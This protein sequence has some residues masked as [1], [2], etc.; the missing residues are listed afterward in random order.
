MTPK[1][2]VSVLES[3]SAAKDV[4]L[5]GALSLAGWHESHLHVVHVGPSRGSSVRAIADYTSRVGADL[6]VVGK[7]ASFAAA[8]GTAANIPTIAFPNDAAESAEAST[9]FRHILTAIDFSKASFLALSEALALAQQS[10][11]RL[12]LLHVLDGF[13]YESVYSGSRAL[14][15]MRDFRARVATVNRELQSLIPRAALNWGEIEVAT[16]YGKAHKAILTAASERRSDLIVLGLPR[17]PRLEQFLAGSTAHSVLRRATSPVLLVPGP[18]TVSVSRLADEHADQ[19]A[20]FPSAVG[21]R[22]VG[23]TVRATE[24]RAS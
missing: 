23:G 13:P 21:W 24:G 15:L 10:G 19:F 2:I 9:P 18:A 17:R 3:S 6:V 22:A 4:A 20:R 14:H 11:G 1:T 12:T 16:V 5:I 7:K 8:I